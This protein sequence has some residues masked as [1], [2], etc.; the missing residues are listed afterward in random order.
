[1]D[2][3]QGR[4]ART[5]LA[6]L[7][8]YGFA[9]AGGFALQA[10]G[11]VERMSED[12]D[13]FTDRW[14]VASFS[15]AVDRL[16]AGYRDLGL[17]VT[18]VRRGETFARLRIDDTATGESA[19]VDVAADSRVNTPVQL[20]TGLV[21]DERDAVANKVAAVFSRGEARD[22]LDLAGILASGR[23]RRS[24]L[25]GLG[26]EADR[27]FTTDL[28]AQALAAADRFSDEEFA[29]YGVDPDH[30]ASV[31]AAMRDWSDAIVDDL[32]RDNPGT[33]RSGPAR[34]LGHPVGRGPGRDRSAAGHDEGRDTP[35][36]GAPGIE[37]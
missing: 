32:A 18:V 1:M 34:D 35:A 2:A 12:V 6:T 30:I 31:R 37:L 28:F 13:L 20:S 16:C 10:H 11:L 4:L 22:Y 3:F 26:A 36:R 24:E 14:D 17:E 33:D 5:G 23:Y 7:E 29:A 27:G 8:D 19:S 15:E 21:L 9:L 25:I